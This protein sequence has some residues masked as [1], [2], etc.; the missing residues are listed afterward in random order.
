MSHITAEDLEQVSLKH[1]LTEFFKGYR[2]LTG[3]VPIDRRHPDTVQGF[4]SK[5]KVTEMFLKPDR[6]QLLFATGLCFVSNGEAFFLTD[7]GGF[8]YN[9]LPP[10]FI[11]CSISRLHHNFGEGM[12]YKDIDAIL[13]Q[14]CRGEQHLNSMEELLEYIN[15]SAEIPA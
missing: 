2:A 6:D 13:A 14:F 10:R 15:I 8:G 11:A 7:D 9:V 4:L 1:H 3:K 12:R 5:E